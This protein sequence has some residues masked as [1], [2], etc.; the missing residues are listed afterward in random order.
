MAAKQEGVDKD[1]KDDISGGEA[2]CLALG[3]VLFCGHLPMVGGAS[4]GLLVWE[5]VI[6]VAEA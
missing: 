6:N 5:V 3:W 4:A 1:R 2:V